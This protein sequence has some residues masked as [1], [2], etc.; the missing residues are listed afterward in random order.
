MVLLFDRVLPSS[1]GG[2]LMRKFSFLAVL[3]AVLALGFSG[4][5]SAEGD[6]SGGYTK[7][8]DISTPDQSIADSSSSQTT[9]SGN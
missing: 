8:V 3:A 6:C 4:Q 2:I 1:I 7:S 5:V 9:K